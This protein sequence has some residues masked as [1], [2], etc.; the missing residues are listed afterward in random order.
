MYVSVSQRPP[1]PEHCSL[2]AL[3]PLFHA[4]PTLRGITSC[5]I[6]TKGDIEGSACYG[7]LSHAFRVRFER[8]DGQGNASRLGHNVREPRFH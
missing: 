2:V 4:A 5:P 7:R 8:R 3:A 1:L 6:V